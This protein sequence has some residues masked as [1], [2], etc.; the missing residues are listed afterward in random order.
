MLFGMPCTQFDA[1]S[2]KNPEKPYKGNILKE[3]GRQEFGLRGGF[4]GLGPSLRKV[5]GDIGAEIAQLFKYT[6]LFQP[7]LSFEMYICDIWSL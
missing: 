6:P 5:K 4:V 3:K 1:P 2:S 7:F